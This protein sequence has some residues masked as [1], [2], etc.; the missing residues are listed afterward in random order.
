MILF[1]IRLHG[2]KSRRGQ[3]GVGEWAKKN[4]Q[5]LGEI[6][7]GVGEWAKKSKSPRRVWVGEST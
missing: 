6:L 7:G 4:N 5:K 2:E 3:K 1:W